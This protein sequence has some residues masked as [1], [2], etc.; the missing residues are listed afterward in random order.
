MEIRY[1]SHPEHVKKFDTHKVREEFLIENLF[2]A[3]QFNLTYSHFDRV[4]VGGA[5]PVG[6][7]LK[8]EGAET[9]SADS[10]LS[11]A[12]EAL[13]ISVVR[14]KSLWTKK[15]FALDP[16]MHSTSA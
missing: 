13:L 6:A 1:S 2:V 15:S 14:E 7:A 11:A 5:T 8:L 16:L 4:I 3:G 12:K 10:F 9:L